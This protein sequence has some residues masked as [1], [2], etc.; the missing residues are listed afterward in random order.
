MI[1]IHPSMTD[2][3]RYT[4]VHPSIV[5]MSDCILR[6]SSKIFF[7]LHTVV[8]NYVSLMV[9]ILLTKFFIYPYRVVRLCSWKRGYFLVFRLML[10]NAFIYFLEKIGKLFNFVDL[11]FV[12]FMQ[13]SDLP[14]ESY[15]TL[16][17]EDFL[18]FRLTQKCFHQL[19]WKFGK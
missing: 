14:L 6:M 1:F 3:L 8:L 9:C 18:V 15:G 4:N 13:N 5:L 11:L 2:I 19:F 17:T 7:K 16:K 12:N 10:K